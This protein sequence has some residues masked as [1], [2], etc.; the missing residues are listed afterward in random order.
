MTAKRGTVL[1]FGS[2][3]VIGSERSWQYL[4]G[5]TERVDALSQLIELKEGRKSRVA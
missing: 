2:N 5:L 1:K 3:K 4:I